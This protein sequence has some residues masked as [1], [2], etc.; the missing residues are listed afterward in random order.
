MN[1][2]EPR[3]AGISGSPDEALLAAFVGPNWNSHYRDSFAALTAVRSG[4]RVG[5]GSPFNWAAML[6]PFWLAYR[7]FVLLQ[8]GAMIAFLAL[9][10][11]AILMTEP[12][13]NDGWGAAVLAYLALGALQG[14]G[15]DPLLH[16][17]ALR[18]LRRVAVAG[19]EGDAALTRLRRM[20]GVSLLAPVATPVAFVGTWMVLV[21]DL[22]FHHHDHERAYVAAMKSDLRNLVT[23]Q[24][25]YFADSVTYTA[26]PAVMVPVWTGTD[27]TGPSP[28]F[29]PSSGATITI[30]VVTG[31]GWNA[32]ARHNGTSRT[33]GIFVGNA[34]PPVAGALEGEP[35]CT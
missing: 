20:G 23:A 4:E 9:M 28:Y 19:L 7:K 2:A 27:T 17:R 6:V 16:R 31:T 33:C 11:A 30:G 13:R 18:A 29:L 14:F 34:P 32:T 26:D 12:L 5:L 22:F 25:V 3:D 10:V 1:P 35:K 8:V 21:P 24:E 15:G